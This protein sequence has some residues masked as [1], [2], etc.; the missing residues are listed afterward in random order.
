MALTERLTEKKRKPTGTPC[1]VGE[2]LAALP[3]S[4]RDALHAM[5]YE[6]GWSWSRIHDALAAE[7]HHVSGQQIN[8]HRSQACRCWKVDQ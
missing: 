3:D 7:G 6:L 5:L 2:L 4:E 1:S 8:R